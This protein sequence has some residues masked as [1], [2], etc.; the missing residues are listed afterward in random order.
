MNSCFFKKLGKNP[1]FMHLVSI[2]LFLCEFKCHKLTW[3]SSGDKTT[4][5][6][7]LVSDFPFFS[8]KNFPISWHTDKI[9]K[10]SEHIISFWTIDKHVAL[11]A[12]GLTFPSGPT[13]KWLSPILLQHSC[14]LSSAHQ[15][16]TILIE[17][18]VL[19]C[20]KSPLHFVCIWLLHAISFHLFVNIHTKKGFKVNGLFFL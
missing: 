14:G 4:V 12:R 16:A 2:S 15:C 1:S 3:N 6:K 11:P 17:I 18:A 5:L 8:W 7:A 9:L 19:S 10:F 13:N 20:K